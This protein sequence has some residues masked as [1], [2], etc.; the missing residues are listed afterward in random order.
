MDSRTEITER[1]EY[2]D[3]EQTNIDQTLELTYT[4]LRLSVIQNRI[5][6]TVN[7][8]T[9]NPMAKMF[10]P[11]ISTAVNV[12]DGINMIINFIPK[13]IYI[14]SSTNIGMDLLKQSGLYDYFKTDN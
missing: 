4:D 12:N 1:I 3:K 9:S 10:I 14:V 5:Q 7:T 2:A 11:L 8:I 13:F 6:N